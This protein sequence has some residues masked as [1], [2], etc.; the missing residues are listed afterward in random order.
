MANENLHL[1]KNLLSDNDKTTMGKP[2]VLK[3][4]Y[5]IKKSWFFLL[6][7]LIEGASL[8]AVELMGAKLL[9]PFYGSS[10]YVWTAVLGITVLG[11]SLGYFFGG[12]L[13][14][15][16]P[17]GK[18]LILIMSIAALLVFALPATAKTV[19][20]LTSSM[21]LI[22]GICIASTESQQFHQVR[23]PLLHSGKPVDMDSL[24]LDANTLNMKDAIVFTDDR[25]LLDRLNIN[26][27][28][29]WHKSYNGTYSRFF[30]DNGVPLFN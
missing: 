10:L 3:S 8:M 21:A 18:L 24:F 26:A 14:V 12:Q 20:F 22:P 6:I 27:N 11:L 29:I 4:S 9:A 28:A 30:L 16:R 25:P 2:V 23:S 1:V 13:S 15:K 7:L 19:I 5:P 17:T